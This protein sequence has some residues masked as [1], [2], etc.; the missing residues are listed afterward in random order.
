MLK[1]FQSFNE[2]RELLDVQF[3][4]YAFADLIDE[5]AI[6]IGG[7][8]YLSIYVNMPSSNNLKSMKEYKDHYKKLGETIEEVDIAIKRIEDELGISAIIKRVLP[9]RTSSL[10][11]WALRIIY[12]LYPEEEEDDDDII[13]F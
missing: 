2:A 5:G 6:V 10:G 4:K 3:I 12:T 9:Y 11:D 8:T 13:P 7:P 1:N